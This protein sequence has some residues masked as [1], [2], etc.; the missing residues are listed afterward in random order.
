MTATNHA[1]TGAAVGLLIGQPLVAI[2]VALVSHYVCDAIP[3]YKS[4]VPEKQHLKSRGFQNYLIAEAAICFL[5][6]LGLVLIRPEHW[7]LAAICAFLAAAPDLISIDKFMA[8]R[9]GKKWQPSIYN[10]F[11]GGI[12]WFERPSGAVVEIA[13]FVAVV[14][15]ILPF[16]H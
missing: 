10:K 13:W 12:Q 15:I 11:A 14:S 7:L 5:I 2:P 3:H 9:R 8:F 6:V 4:A 1:L 16:L